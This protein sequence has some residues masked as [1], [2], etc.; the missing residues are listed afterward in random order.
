MQESWAKLNHNG[1]CV[2]PL[3]PVTGIAGYRW[4]ISRLAK[5]NEAK[6]VSAPYR[7]VEGYS[8][9]K[10][11]FGISYTVLRTLRNSP[12]ELNYFKLLVHD[13]PNMMSMKHLRTESKSQLR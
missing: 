13:S 10:G 4:Y 7:K 5:K 1:V 6:T 3:E 12:V 9:S 8:E 11:H 2:L